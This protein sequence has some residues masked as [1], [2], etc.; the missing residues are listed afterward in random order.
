MHF[1]HH[2]AKFEAFKRFVRSKL[3]KTGFVMSG[4]VDRR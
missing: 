4:Y 3:A 2:L 1:D